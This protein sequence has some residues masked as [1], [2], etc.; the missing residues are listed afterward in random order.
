MEFD[1]LRL[2]NEAWD[3]HTRKLEDVTTIR[4]VQLGYLNKLAYVDPEYFPDSEA[5]DIGL[6]IADTDSL[7]SWEKEFGEYFLVYVDSD[8][9]YNERR[10]RNIVSLT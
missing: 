10:L 3:Y 4:N 9:K 5:L 7:T 6:Y 2:E 8:V 1:G